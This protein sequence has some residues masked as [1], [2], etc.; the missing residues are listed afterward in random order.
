MGGDWGTK[1]VSRRIS[2]RLER[3]GQVQSEKRRTTDDEKIKR[4]S[5]AWARSQFKGKK[6][7]DFFRRSAKKTSSLN[8]IVENTNTKKQKEILK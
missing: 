1:N 6:G 4:T 5:S 7:E 3:E 8:F 2:T